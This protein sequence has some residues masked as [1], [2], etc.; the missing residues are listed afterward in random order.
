[1]LCSCTLAQTDTT[2]KKTL[3]DQQSKEILKK[4][5]I[6]TTKFLKDFAVEACKCIDSISLINKNSE[7]ISSAISNC[8]D[9][10]VSAYQ[11][12]IKLYRSMS[13]TGKNK[14]ITIEVGKN[15]NEYKYYYFQIEHWLK[16]SCKPLN[17]AV[18]ANN[19]ESEYSFSKNGEA[20]AYYRKGAE[21]LGN[22]NYKEAL[23]YFENAVKRDSKFAFAWDNIGICNRR[24][25]NFDAAIEAYNKSLEIDPKGK[26]PL[27]NIAVAYEYKKN[28]DKAL[29]AYLNILTYYPDD[30]EAY[31]GAGRIYAYFKPDYEKALQYM[32]KAYNIY[33]NIKSPYRVDAEKQVSYLY[34]KM[35]ND[36]KEELFSK[37]LKNNNITPS[38]N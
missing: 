7:E 9:K 19:K 11:L 18:A 16:D 20:L 23:S 5:N 13:D 3:S 36:G 37:I 35:K 10:Q 2:E 34:G 26:T 12:L 32:C 30:P 27:Q 14:N 28:Y 31:Y 15:S 4:L 6:D 29:E 21:A 17:K 24:L 38:K 1:M 25:N 33:T 22:E 8:I